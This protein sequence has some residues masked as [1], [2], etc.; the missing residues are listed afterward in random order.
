MKSR[1]LCA[2]GKDAL[3]ETHT[4]HEAPVPRAETNSQSAQENHEPL[5]LQRT[6]TGLTRTRLNGPF[7]HSL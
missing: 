1:S 7:G 5:N 6:R 3:L 4:P 2:H